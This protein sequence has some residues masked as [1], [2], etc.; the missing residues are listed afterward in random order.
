MTTDQKVSFTQ[1]KDGTKE[2]YE[3][4]EKLE[5]PY[6]ALTADRIM[7]ELRRQGEVSLEG[8]RITRLEHGLQSGTR[9]L[10]EGADIDWVVGALLHDIGDGLAPQNH[11]RFSAEVIRPFVRDEVAW[12]VE[13]HGIFQMFY[14]G[15]HYGWDKDARDRFKDHPC[16]QSCADFCERWDQSS[17]DPDYAYEP[18]EVFE[19]MVR[20]V[21]ARKAY[22][23]EVVQE[24]VVMGLPELA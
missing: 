2:D 1:M 11:D 10:R 18:L 12:V 19:P 9:A 17:F 24:G 5:K 6:L 16:W 7:D 21:F 13:H 22:D 8:Y 23:P 4:L 3:L 14:Y 15:H 20:E